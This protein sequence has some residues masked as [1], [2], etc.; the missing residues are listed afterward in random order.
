MGLLDPQSFDRVVLLWTALAVVIAAVLTRVVAP[1][2]R[3]ALRWGPMVPGWLGWL[4]M[5]APSPLGMILLYALGPNRGVATRIFLGLWLLHYVHRTVIYPL[6]RRSIG[7]PMP[8]FVALLAVLFNLM[9]AGTN[10]L[11][12]FWLGPDRGVAWLGDPRFLGGLA[13]FLGG[14][15]INVQ[16]DEIL[17]R[18]RRP[19]ERGYHIPRGGLY[20]W[21]SCPNYLGEIVE[22]W[23]FALLTWSLAGLGFAVWTSAVLGTRALSHHA[24]YRQ[25]FADYPPERRALVPGLL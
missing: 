13:L 8:A 21:V 22:W 4:L 14:L 17:R 10:G 5:E 12:L 9:N 15:A 19:G 23:G 2:G 6:L 7:N 1:Y 25:T 16:S 20:R 3:H 18:L 11:G 24:W